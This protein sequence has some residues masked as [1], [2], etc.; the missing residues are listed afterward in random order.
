MIGTRLQMPDA[1]AGYHIKRKASR[2]VGGPEGIRTLDLFHAMEARSQLR[3]R[4][5]REEHTHN[6]I[7]MVWRKTHKRLLY[8][9]KTIGDGIL[10]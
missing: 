6:S 3:H 8:L 2:K 5:T 4:P 7:R 10:Q 9:Y 1:L